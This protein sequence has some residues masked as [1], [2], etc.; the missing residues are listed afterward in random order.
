MSSVE[1]GRSSPLPSR[2]SASKKLNETVL[3]HNHNAGLK[4]ETRE[5]GKEALAD[6]ILGFVQQTLFF[7]RVYYWNVIL[8]CTIIDLTFDICVEQNESLE[9][10]SHQR[11]EVELTNSLCVLGSAGFYAI[12]MK[13]L[14]LFFAVGVRSNGAVLQRCVAQPC[15]V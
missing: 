9:A 11:S 1:G 7:F 2:N 14:F 5:G 13:Y 3:R 10:P 6:L 8:V 12:E 4:E 15:V